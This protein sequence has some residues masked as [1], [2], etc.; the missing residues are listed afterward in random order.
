VFDGNIHDARTLQDIVSTIR[1][2][3][4]KSGLI[5]YDRG[6]TSAENL[7]V[8]HDLYWDT[9]CGVPI[10]GNLKKILQALIKNNFA[11]I[12]NWVKCN[13]TIFYVKIIPYKIGS[14]KGTLAICFN[15]RKE[16]DLHESRYAEIKHAEQLLSQGKKVKAGLE[17]YFDSKGKIIKKK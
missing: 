15:K 4:I 1:H 11:S 5:I 9:L 3:N 6:I 17:I 13:K 12:E 10:R 7:E 16:N 2:Y 8:F 14:V